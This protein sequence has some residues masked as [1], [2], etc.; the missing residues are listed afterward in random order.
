[1]TDTEL[2]GI[3]VPSFDQDTELLKL[4]ELDHPDYL[5]KRDTAAKMFG[6]PKG[7]LDKVV[8]RLRT[9]TRNDS[10]PGDRIAFTDI[11]PW[12]YPVDGIQL[13]DD[14][15]KEIRRFVAVDKKAI[16]AV[17][18]WCLFTHAFEAF[19]ISPRLFLTS[20]EKRCGKTT[21]L[22]VINKIVRKPML[23]SNTSPSA[24]F[25]LAD[26]EQPTIMLDEADGYIKENEDFRNLINAGHEI[27]NCK[28]IRVTGE[29]TN[30]TPSVFRIWVPFVIAGIGKLQSTIEDRSI[31]I[32]MRR[33][34]GNE[35]VENARRKN[36][37][38]LEIFARKSARW[39]ADN[40]ERLKGMEPAMPDSLNDR[41]CDNW[42]P[43]LSIADVIGGDWPDKLREAAIALELAADAD[44]DASAGVMLLSDCWQI[45]E[46]ENTDRISSKNL[47]VSL[48][49]LE[50][51]PWCEWRRGNPITQNGVSRLLKTF[52]IAPSQM[53]IGT[54]NLRGYDKRNFKEPFY[55]YVQSEKTSISSPYPK[56]GYY[57]A[58]NGAELPQ[59]GNSQPLQDSD[60]Y[61]L[62][63]PENPQN[64]N[65]CNVVTVSKGGTG[66]KREK[67]DNSATSK[68]WAN[69][70]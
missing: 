29:G 37:K 40:I 59:N 69:E 48:N 38:S 3:A 46:E 2:A 70:I 34:L 7:E 36:L 39:G 64:T 26:A 55:R 10:G 14:L 45:F 11:E 42:E 15:T 19:E 13:L 22:K 16:H 47:I 21:L 20:P 41:A 31:I 49:D 6:W 63:N 65:V 17:A 58:T 8:E 62:Q 18:A 33:R 4:A 28:V 30:M 51:R 53:R 9:K 61:H 43:L 56:S 57:N 25:R 54:S 44:D 66:A 23:A 68:T 5:N 27:D 52:G 24:M 60:L 32:R 12:N 35:K 67:S 1:M 50:G